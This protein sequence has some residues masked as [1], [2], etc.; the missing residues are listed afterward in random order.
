[1]HG[2]PLEL[3]ADA[4]EDNESPGAPVLPESLYE[5]QLELR[6]GKAPEW[7]GPAKTEWETLRAQVLPPF[8]IAEIA[9]QDLHK[10]NFP[11]GD[12]LKDWSDMMA[13]QEL[14]WAV[15]LQ[16]AAPVPEVS[17]DKD[18]VLL[19]TIL[20]AMATYASPLPVK[21]EEKTLEAGKSVYALPPALKVDVVATDQEVTISLPM[22]S[23][24]QA[25]A[26]N[27]AALLRAEELAPACGASLLVEPTSLK[28]TIPR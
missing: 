10:E 6:L 25:Q 19:R 16:L 18:Y 28:L 23:D 2:K 20:Q 15:P 12:L 3:K 11:L 5:A 13:A 22:P 4:L 14:G 24:A 8:A 9:G 17:L 27:K 7:V 26:K 21:D 1:L